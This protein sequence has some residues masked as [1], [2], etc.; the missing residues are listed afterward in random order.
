MLLFCLVEFLF[1]KLVCVQAI[2][3][4]KKHQLEKKELVR[5]LDG[6]KATLKEKCEELEEL[7]REHCRYMEESQQKH[8]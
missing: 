5:E 3:V 7:Q 1:D 2:E 8:R 6:V 4:E